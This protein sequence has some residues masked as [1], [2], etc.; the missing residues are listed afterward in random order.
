VNA[1]FIKTPSSK[2][3]YCIRR[4]EKFWLL[5]RKDTGQ[6]LALFDTQQKAVSRAEC[7]ARATLPS[8]LDIHHDTQHL[9][10]RRY[11]FVSAEPVSNETLPNKSFVGGSMS[12]RSLN[13]VQ[14]YREESR[15]RNDQRIRP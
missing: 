4:Q 6:G 12:E 8:Q 14:K 7:L 10:V 2:A 3:H 1:P 13:N 5:E 15:S 9:E 11:P